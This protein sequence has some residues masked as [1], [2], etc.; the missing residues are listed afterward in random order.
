MHTCIGGEIIC[1]LIQICSDLVEP[2]NVCVI[3]TAG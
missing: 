3:L 2:L 1:G